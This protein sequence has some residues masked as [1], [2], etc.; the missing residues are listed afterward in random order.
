MAKVAVPKKSCVTERQRSQIGLIVVFFSRSMNGSGSSF[1]RSPS[2][3][4]NFV[5]PMQADR[6]LKIGPI[7]RLAEH[8]AEFPVH[9]DI[10]IGVDQARHI[11]Q[12]AAER[13]DHVDLGADAFDQALDLGQ[14][15]GM[16]KTP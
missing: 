16:L 5:V 1:R 4:R 7:Q 2:E 6:G 9:A 8:A 14:V 3:R 12:M 10:D 15:G 13:K 11:R